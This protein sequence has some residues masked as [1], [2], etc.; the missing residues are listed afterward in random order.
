[1]PRG[2]E[3][4][5]WVAS[6]AV[7]PRTSAVRLACDE[8]DH[9]YAGMARSVSRS[10]KPLQWQQ[11]CSGAADRWGRVSSSRAASIRSAASSTTTALTLGGVVSTY[12][13]AALTAA[14][15]SEPAPL[16][17]RIHTVH[18]LAWGSSSP[19]NSASPAS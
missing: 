5:A 14:V 13:G 15:A 19:S 11:T 17:G 1:M 18:E 16:I 6:V 3:A 2:N 8:S 9:S 7:Q 12:T 4:H 10:V